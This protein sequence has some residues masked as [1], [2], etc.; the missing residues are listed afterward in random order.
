MNIEISGYKS[1]E[2]CNLDITDNKINMIFGM[3]GSG[4]SSIASALSKK[5]IE[6]NR[7]IGKISRLLLK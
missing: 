1:I 3:S 5:N 6:R 4:K 2:K 7:T